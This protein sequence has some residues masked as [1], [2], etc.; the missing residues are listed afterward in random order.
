MTKQEEIERLARFCT[1][2]P[3]DSYLYDMIVE[4]GL[5]GHIIRQIENDLGFIDWNWMKQKQSL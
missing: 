5:E 1:S 3:Q 4:D 2:L